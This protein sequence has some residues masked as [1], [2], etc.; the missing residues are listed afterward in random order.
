[1]CGLDIDDEYV[2]TIKGNVLRGFRLADSA[3]VAR[4]DR[5]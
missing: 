2:L 1:M 3:D 4:L 5:A